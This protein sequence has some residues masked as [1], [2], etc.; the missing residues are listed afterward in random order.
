VLHKSTFTIT[1]TINKECYQTWAWYLRSLRILP[2]VKFQTSMKPSTEPVIKYWP[3]GEN[4]PHSTWA[5]CPNWATKQT[6]RSMINDLRSDN[7]LTSHLL[8]GK[9][10]RQIAQKQLWWQ[11][12]V[13][14]HSKPED[15]ATQ[16]NNLDKKNKKI[17]YLPICQILVAFSKLDLPIYWH[18]C[19]SGYV[20]LNCQKTYWLKT[21]RKPW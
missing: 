9:R 5:F 18:N 7:F 19:K 21:E 15:R 12:S 8:S 17:K 20:T 10:K 16:T 11:T 14:S 3:S 6:W 4:L 13:A 2:V 1:I